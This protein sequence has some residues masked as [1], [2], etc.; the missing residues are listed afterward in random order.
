MIDRELGN[1][2]FPAGSAWDRVSYQAAD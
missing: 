1:R 2:P